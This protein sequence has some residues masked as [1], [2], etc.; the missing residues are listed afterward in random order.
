MQKAGKNGGEIL[1]PRAAQALLSP[2]NYSTIGVSSV[3][4]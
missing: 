4:Q 1:L 3:K 2:K